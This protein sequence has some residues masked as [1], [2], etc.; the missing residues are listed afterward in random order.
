[1]EIRLLET[2]KEDLRGGW[3]LYE[4]IAAGLGDC[5]LDCMQADVRSLKVFAGIHE[6]SELF[7]QNFDWW[8]T[9][10]RFL[11]IDSLCVTWGIIN[12][13][14]KLFSSDSTM[15]Y[16]TPCRDPVKVVVL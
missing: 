6:M 2:A 9:C 16:F 5:F 10:R 13:R 11:G 12:R 4:Q 7:H 1:M 8:P 3:K 14:R 15:A